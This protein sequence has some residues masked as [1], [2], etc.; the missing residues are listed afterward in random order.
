MRNLEELSLRPEDYFHKIPCDTTEAGREEWG[1]G[2]LGQIRLEQDVLMLVWE[3]RA[4]PFYCEERR[5]ILE[6]LQQGYAIYGKISPFG[7]GF[8]ANIYGFQEK[9]WA[10]QWNVQLKQEQ[11]EWIAKLKNQT[12]DTLQNPS[13]PLTLKL[14][15][16]AF[17][18]TLG[19]YATRN[20]KKQGLERGLEPTFRLY[21]E[22]Y[23]LLL[24][25]EQDCLRVVD[26]EKPPKEITTGLCVAMGKLQFS[27]EKNLVPESARLRIEESQGAEYIKLWD[28]YAMEEG[29][30]LLAKIRKVGEIVFKSLPKRQYAGDNHFIYVGELADPKQGQRLHQVKETQGTLLLSP[31][32]PYHLNEAVTWAEYS[33][34]RKDS[35]QRSLEQSC[36]FVLDRAKNTLIMRHENHQNLIFGEEEPA[37]EEK[38]WQKDE[39]KKLPKIYVTLD[40]GGDA[41]RIK[42]RNQGRN[43]MMDGESANP[44]MAKVMEGKLSHKTTP[45]EV[46][47]PLTLE[48][49]VAKTFPQGATASQRRALVL[50]L[51]TPDIALIQGPSGTGKTTVIKAVMEGINQELWGKSRQ[52][53]EILITSYQHDAVDHVQAKLNINSIPPVKFQGQEHK[54]EKSAVEHWCQQWVERF[55]AKHGHVGNSLQLEKLQQKYQEYVNFPA[56]EQAKEFLDYGDALAKDPENKEWIQRLRRAFD[57]EKDDGYLLSRVRKLRVTPQGMADD[58]RERSNEVIVA[59]CGDLPY[60][61]PKR[62]ARLDLARKRFPALFQSLILEKEDMTPAFF[63]ACAKEKM[64]LLEESLGKPQKP[65]VNPDMG[66]LVQSLSREWKEYDPD[67]GAMVETAILTDLLQAVGRQSTVSLQK[68]MSKYALVY[69]ATLQHSVAKPIYQAKQGDSK[70]RQ[71]HISFDTVIVDEAARA[72]PMDLMIAITQGRRR[73]ILVGDHRQLP[74]V[75]DEELLEMLQETTGISLG[76]EQSKESMFQY[77]MKMAKKL[78]AQ[79]NI[80]RSITLQEQ[81]RMHPLLGDFVNRQFYEKYSPEEAFSSPLPASHFAQNLEPS[82]L[83]WLDVPRNRGAQQ[84]WNSTWRRPAETKVIGEKLCDY[85][86]RGEETIGIITFYSGQKAD[87]V[88]QIQQMAQLCPHLVDKLK[89]VEVGTVDSFQGKE[90]DVIFLSLVRSALPDKNPEEDKGRKTYGFLTMENRLCVALS[91]QKKL[92]V[93]VGNGEIYGGDPLWRDLAEREVPALANFYALCEKEG[94]VEAYGE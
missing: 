73:L 86:E 80:P 87:M 74:Q 27:P 70:G 1:R 37:E 81:F 22:E 62:K 51:N 15:E 50:A 11:K 54:V 45:Q 17:V 41:I 20:E 44:P 21:G 2:V 61:D 4:V 65:Q 63:Q 53:G 76:L 92:L 85:L 77:L 64:E 25:M 19:Y 30:M 13:V 46:L 90:F 49:V 60:D 12:A 43:R 91:R 26:V 33:Q 94:R 32:I 10:G 82:P 52:A 18:Y 79:D 3:E 7:K 40:L 67:T 89:K 5:G 57:K 48:E 56:E 69:G 6:R 93:V 16:T 24:R 78:E 83:L 36:H 34:G 47:D 88:E 84:R 31:Q 29:K 28:S 71:G 42:R 68:V 8:R 35:F 38:L 55:V 14:Q 75:Y 23:C 58:G 72:N 59:L 66:K 9:F 39:K